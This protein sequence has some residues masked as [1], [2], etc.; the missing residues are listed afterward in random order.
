VEITTGGAVSTNRIIASDRQSARLAG[1]ALVA[2][3]RLYRSHCAICGVE[4]VGMTR[5]RFC[6]GTHQRQ[7]YR[8]RAAHPRPDGSIPDPDE[9]YGPS[10]AVEIVPNGVDHEASTPP[11]AVGSSSSSL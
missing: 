3:R 2:H 11:A 5:R 1:Q 6:G 7:S 8:E 9:W 10:D 4:I